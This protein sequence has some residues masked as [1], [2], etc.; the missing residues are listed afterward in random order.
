MKKTTCPTCG[1]GITPKISSSESTGSVLDAY[2]PKSSK[3]AVPK[4]CEYRERFKN[5]QVGLNDLRAKPTI[6][7]IKKQ[8]GNLDRFSY[9]GESL[10]F[11]EGL[12][13]EI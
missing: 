12:V 13:Q 4:V 8:D 9:K 6:L 11:G 3:R 10:F 7:Q 1:Q 2:E 5:K